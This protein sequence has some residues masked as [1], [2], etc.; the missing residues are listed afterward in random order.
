MDEKLLELLVPFP[1]DYI[2]QKP[3]KIQA[4]YVTHGV[5]RQRLL[6]VLGFYEWTIDREI[7]NSDGSLTGCVG[8]LTVFLD[9]VPLKVQGS[10]DVEHNQGSNGANLKHAESDAF[11]RAA[12]NLG[13]GLHLWC[14]DEYFI[15]NKNKKKGDESTDETKADNS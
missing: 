14:D 5:V 1:K 6:D 10:G 4:S 3:G 8:T 15:Y 11:K 9:G 12:M 2:K 7:F 13:L